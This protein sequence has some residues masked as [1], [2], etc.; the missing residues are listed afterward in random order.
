MK[1]EEVER[2]VE[3][4]NSILQS[5]KARAHNLINVECSACGDGSN[6]GS[7]ESIELYLSSVNKSKKLLMIIQNSILTCEQV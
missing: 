5:L 6:G 7:N 4:Y 3:D 1:E 2:D